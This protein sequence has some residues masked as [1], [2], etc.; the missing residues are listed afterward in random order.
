MNEWDG[1]GVDSA[2]LGMGFMHP[3][4]RKHQNSLEG[5]FGSSPTG[6]LLG[7]PSQPSF[8]YSLATWKLP[9]SSWT[10]DSSLLIIPRESLTMISSFLSEFLKC[11]FS[12]IYCK[13]LSSAWR[14]LH[15]LL[16]QHSGLNSFFWKSFSVP[17]PILPFHRLGCVSSFTAFLSLVRVL[18]NRAIHNH[19]FSSLTEPEVLWRKGWCLA[20]DTF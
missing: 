18:K 1:G 16:F 5:C 9:P 19:S 6:W 7:T 8:P 11:F 14:F 12:H 17:Y 20:S 4:F 10:C 3:F 13:T 15:R 2:G